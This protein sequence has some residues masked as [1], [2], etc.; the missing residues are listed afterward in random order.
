MWSHQGLVAV[1]KYVTESEK[2]FVVSGD[3]CPLWW[4]ED[5]AAALE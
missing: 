4:E 2:K 3:L 1:K 5:D